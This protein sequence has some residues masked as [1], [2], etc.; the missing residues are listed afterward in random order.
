MAYVMSDVDKTTLHIAAVDVKG[1]P[2]PLENVVWSVSD[3]T[4]L[5][6]TPAPDGLSCEVLAVGALG[7]SQVNV[8]ADAQVGDGVTNLT[9]L[10][11][12]TIVASQ[13]VTLSITADPP[14]PQ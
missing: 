4:I 1:N 11:D 6:A 13:A 5:T 8:L 9:G 7:T 3:A 2:A 14:V 12:A 10:F